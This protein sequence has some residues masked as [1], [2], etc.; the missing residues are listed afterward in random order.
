MRKSSSEEIRIN[1]HDARQLKGNAEYNR[2]TQIIRDEQVKA[3]TD[4]SA[5]DIVVREEAHA[6]LRALNLIDGK[7]DSFINDETIILEKKG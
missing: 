7:L 1:A 2:F 4:S 3:F 5:T 6:I